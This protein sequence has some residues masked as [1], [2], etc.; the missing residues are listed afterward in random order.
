MVRSRS[1]SPSGALATI[2]QRPTR[3][4]ADRTACARVVSSIRL[5]SRSPRLVGSLRPTGECLPGRLRG[6]DVVALHRHDE[7]AAA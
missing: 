6:V 4:S 1:R 3:P 5:A 2:A 7:R